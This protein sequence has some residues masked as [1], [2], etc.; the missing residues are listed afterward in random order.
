MPRVER[1]VLAVRYDGGSF[2]KRTI[3]D[4]HQASLLFLVLLLCFFSFVLLHTDM[5]TLAAR[6]VVCGSLPDL[7]TSQT[8]TIIHALHDEVLIGPEEHSVGFSAEYLRA[9]TISLD[10]DSERSSHTNPAPMPLRL[11]SE[12]MFPV[13]MKFQYKAGSI[14]K[15]ASTSMPH[16]V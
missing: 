8:R 9:S 5:P 6:D 1:G 7:Q 16:A 4:R 2:D 12:S 3:L 14:I 13:E 10:C 11:Y 15:L